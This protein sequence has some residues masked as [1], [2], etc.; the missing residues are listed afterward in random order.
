ME[1][2]NTIGYILIH[3]IGSKL[4]N[5]RIL[6]TVIAITLTISFIAFTLDSGWHLVVWLFISNFAFAF[7]FPLCLVLTVTRSVEAAE[8]RSL[9]IMTQ[10]VGYLMAAISPG[11]V[12][13]IFDISNSWNTAWLF[14]IGIGVIL[15]GVGYKAGSP[16]KIII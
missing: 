3:T 6:L 4:K 12:A 16:E 15:I 14:L 7:A 11:I 9:S 5:F 13:V 10:S 2:F 8:T 1:F